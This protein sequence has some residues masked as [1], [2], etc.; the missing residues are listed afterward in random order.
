M[1]ECAWLMEPIANREQT[2]LTRQD[3]KSSILSEYVS[4][5]HPETV[6]MRLGGV[7]LEVGGRGIWNGAGV[8]LG[9]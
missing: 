3:L 1:I 9:V 8:R 6:A 2:I 4:L 5:A 7:G